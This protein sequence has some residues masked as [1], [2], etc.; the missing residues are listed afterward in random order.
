MPAVFARI[1][2]GVLVAF[3]LATAT[4]APP[5]VLTRTAQIRA[6]SPEEASREI[7]VRLRAVVTL[8]DPGWNDVF[9]HDETGGVYVAIEGPLDIR[10]G[11]LVEVKGVA[12]PGEFTPVVQKPR[13]RVLGQGRLPQPRKVTYQ[14]LFSGTL[15][16]E[17]VE[18]RGTIRSAVLDKHR[19]NLYLGWGGASNLRATVVEV[20]PTNPERFVNTRVTLRGTS[21][22][23]FT[24]RRQL[25]GIIIHVQ[26][27]DGVIIREPGH[28]Q[29][30]VPL[31]QASSLL[32]FSAKNSV[33]ERARVR[34]V[35]I[36]RRAKELYIRDGEQGLM[37][38]TYQ[39]LAL[40]PGD[41]VEATGF[42][43]LGAYNPILKDATLRR[44]GSGPAPRPF[45]VTA[46]Q[47]VE[48]DHD[49]DLVEIEA[50]LVS[51]TTTEKGQQLGMKSGSHIFSVEV[52]KRAAED[53][54]ALQEG[55]RV[56][57]TGICLME[58][59]EWMIEP[60]A[61]RLLLR[62]GNDIEVL[63]H[64]S[65][66]TLTR[67]LRLLILLALVILGAL[68]WVLLLRRRVN[69]QTK[70]LVRNNQ[71]LERA[72]ASAKEATELKS[73]FLANMSHEIRTP[74]NG[75]LGMTGLAL[76]AD[77]PAEQR[78]YVSDAMKSAESLLAL[79]N[80]ILD[81]SKIEAGR[82]ELD[83]V[84]F[85]V[86]EC[87]GD[88]MAALSVPVHEK[89]L[90]L[91]VRVAP[92]VP[93]H[94]HGDPSRIRQV[95][96]NL[97]NNAI[98]FTSTGA[99]RVSAALFEGVDAT[100][101]RLHFSVADTGV[102]IPEEKLGVI[103]EPFRQ[104]DGSTTRQHG[105]TGLGL[106]ICARLIELMGGNIWVESE[107]GKGSGF[108]F[109]IPMQPASHTAARQLERA[110]SPSAPLET[111]PLRI[112]VAEDNLINQKIA[113]RVLEKAGHEVMVASDGR[114]ALAAWRKQV[115][116]L[117]LMDIQMPHLNGFECTAAI[118]ATE[119][120]GGKRVPILALTAH[121][122]NGY[123]RRCLEAGMDGYISKPMR[124][125]ELLA[126]IHRV[127]LVE[128]GTQV[129]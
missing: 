35:V 68:S 111:P 13:I 6:L 31:E 22:A 29:L 81:F 4:A 46:Q 121:A 124:A 80:D 117:V 59:G 91:E 7:P 101:V 24:K 41:L 21:G 61:F 84:D 26:S 57:V 39:P 53:L 100:P 110:A 97:V 56:R 129:N 58:T 114:E 94:L 55:S 14:E 34:G 62:S 85:S 126:A 63:W 12:G 112:L 118:R 75:I 82:M 104:A 52:D 92:D 108:H 65:W 2:G 74:M 86:R 43:E 87:V 73:Q 38:Q 77:L 5:A 64:P 19:L 11:Q 116:D 127:T 90:A 72:L 78:G 42:P 79:L 37:V 8:Y 16:S 115:F 51:W 3:S 123:D 122:L 18:V 103:F 99:I 89:G 69:A 30:E 49:S 66:W 96:L 10:Q 45:Q 1:T 67:T 36:Y 93:E 83:P 107:L 95:L 47:A 88:A 44:L 40:A 9:V 71:E 60:G 17:F 102:G 70:Q 113:A 119:E 128:A 50:N 20:P 120:P 48:G 23:T 27:L 33:S 98:K 109:I 54:P 76:A 15:D 32:R 106:T 28:D 125:E 25:T 105:G